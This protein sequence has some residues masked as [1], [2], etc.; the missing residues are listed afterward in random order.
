MSMNSALRGSTTTDEPM[1]QADCDRAEIRRGVL[2]ALSLGLDNGSATRSRRLLGE[3]PNMAA[4][5]L[6]RRRIGP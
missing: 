2:A 1:A 6:H 3:T 5:G 4:R